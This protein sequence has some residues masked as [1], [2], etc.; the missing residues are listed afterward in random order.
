MK[1]KKSYLIIG[2]V[3]IAAIIMFY[4]W[5]QSKTTTKQTADQIQVSSRVQEL[6]NKVPYSTRKKIVD[7]YNW[8]LTSGDKLMLKD[9]IVY[10]ITKQ[11]PDEY[12]RTSVEKYRLDGVLWEMR[13][14]YKIIDGDTEWW[15]GHTKAFTAAEYNESLKI[16]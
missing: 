1:L 16:Q 14:N 2:I 12:K 5:K 9:G 8:Q 15:L 10:N 13:T 7:I 11:Q 3:V 4:V 6:A